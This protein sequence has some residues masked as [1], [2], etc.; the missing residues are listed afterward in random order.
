[1]QAFCEVTT[2]QLVSS[3]PLLQKCPLLHGQ[4]TQADFTLQQSLWEN[5]N[6]RKKLIN[7]PSQKIKNPDGTVVLLAPSNT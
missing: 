1:M 4:D 7:L 5:L 2:Y 3:F 6:I